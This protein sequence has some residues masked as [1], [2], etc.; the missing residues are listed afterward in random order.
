[1]DERL[2]RA[3]YLARLAHANQSFSSLAIS[4]LTQASQE[5][6]RMILPAAVGDNLP[7]V[8]RRAH[9]Q[10]LTIE[11][12]IP[13]A[14]ILSEEGDH[15]KMWA[16]L[17]APWMAPDTPNEPA[18][19]S[20][21][22]SLVTLLKSRIPPDGL[23]N[24]TLRHFFQNVYNG[25]NS[26]FIGHDEIVKYWANFP[27]GNNYSN[28]Y[29]IF[30]KGWGHVIEWDRLLNATP[31]QVEALKRLLTPGQALP[32]NNENLFRNVTVTPDLQNVWPTLGRET[33]FAIYHI[34][35]VC[36]PT[37]HISMLAAAITGVVAA[38]I[39]QS[40][41][42]QRWLD[43][44]LLTLKTQCPL[45]ELVDQYI[46]A[47]DVQTF[48]NRYLSHFQDY[49][50]IYKILMPLYSGLEMLD[51]KSISWMIE[52][53]RSTHSAHAIFF[54]NAIM[55]TAGRLALYLEPITF[56]NDLINW[57]AVIISLYH[58]PWCSV[59]GPVIKS[60]KYPDLANLGT[61][62]MVRLETR[63]VSQYGG[64][65][66]MGGNL[67]KGQ[68]E[69][70]ATDVLEIN[71]T[72]E[73]EEAGMFDRI[74]QNLPTGLTLEDT[75][76]DYLV[77]TPPRGAGIL[78]PSDIATLAIDGVPQPNNPNAD[79]ANGQQQGRG[80]VLANL[81]GNLMNRQPNVP[82]VPPADNIPPVQ[83]N[84][85]VQPDNLPQE[86]VRI[87]NRM[88]PHGSYKLPKRDFYNKYSELK[89]QKDFGNVLTTIAGYG[90]ELSTQEALHPY[91]T[92]RTVGLVYPARP[93]PEDL[94][95]AF[96]YLIR[97]NESLATL[98]GVWGDDENNHLPITI[99]REQNAEESDDASIRAW[100]LAA[101]KAAL[102]VRPWPAAAPNQQ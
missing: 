4:G 92:D 56:K 68:V 38:S 60:T 76:E 2:A 43:K 47:G 73:T 77:V 31:D 74:C 87:G 102:A 29:G 45:A 22:D 75:N 84:V 7:L 80:G 89:L 95:K 64:N 50:Q 36:N 90:R 15:A 28:Q 37:M 25:R 70:I 26:L 14:I 40:N 39:K 99:Q 41:A 13:I 101:T 55:Q 98:D 97:R 46:D 48:Y 24:S 79:N 85:A 32:I 65:W 63:T 86:R 93:I 35:A 3:R 49:S 67:S 5:T 52:Q 6:R 88:Y 62:I 58:N 71:N 61:A 66:V 9:R 30:A 34:T 21:L 51:L 11:S 10:P 78:S 33:L 53:S 57:A 91:A 19:T 94:R 8:A 82:V 69:A 72:I 27:A 81:F 100:D 83:G 16:E 17:F 59:L 18:V 42:N 23:L 20:Q 96:K 12:R 44:R 1:M 54:A